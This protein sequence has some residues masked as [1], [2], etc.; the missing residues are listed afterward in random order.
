VLINVFTKAAIGPYTVPDE[1]ISQ[2]VAG[3]RGKVEKKVSF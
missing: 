1:Y 2:K 3:L